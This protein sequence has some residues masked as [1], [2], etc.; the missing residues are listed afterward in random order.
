MNEGE[1]LMRGERRTLW[2]LSVL[3]LFTA[4]QLNPVA[5]HPKGGRTFYIQ[6]NLV[7][8]VPGVAPVTD[9][10]LVNAWGI[11]AG[12]DTPIWVND[13][14]T[15]VSTIYLGDGTPRPL[16]VTIPGPTGSTDA[17]APTGIVYNELAEEDETA[18]VVTS[19]DHSG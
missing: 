2:L 3:V 16:V 10:N 14:G 19:G 18:F 8:D 12:D 11:A 5:A 17:S 7:S 1:V 15:G 9:P 6:H 4:I 13:N